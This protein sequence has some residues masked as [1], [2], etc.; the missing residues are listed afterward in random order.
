MSQAVSVFF[1]NICNLW[2]KGL[3]RKILKSIVLLPKKQIGLHCIHDIHIHHPLLLY[4]SHFQERAFH[5]PKFMINYL[6]SSKDF[7][8]LLTL[9][10]KKVSIKIKFRAKSINFL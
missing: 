1:I 7:S 8:I 3:F 9:I 6:K 2:K 5:S 10:R 4:W